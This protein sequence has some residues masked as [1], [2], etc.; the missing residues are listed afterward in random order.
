MKREDERFVRSAF[1]EKSHIDNL[2]DSFAIE[3]LS[4]TLMLTSNMEVMCSQERNVHM[5]SKRPDFSFKRLKAS[6]R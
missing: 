3:G 6:R 5:V 4:T 2:Q 1:A